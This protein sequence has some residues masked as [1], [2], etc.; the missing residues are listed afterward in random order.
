MKRIS[1]NVFLML[2]IVGGI[3]IAYA[4]TTFIA[5]SNPGATGGTNV[6]T[7]VNSINSAVTAAANGDIIYVVPSSVTYNGPSLNGKQVSIIGGGFNPNKPSGAVSTVSGIYANANNFRL[8]GIVF[9]TDVNIPGPFSNIMIDKCKLKVITDGSGGSAKG[10]LIIQNC[11]MGEGVG[12]AALYI[13]V[14][15][16]NV[17]IS[18]NIIYGNST[19]SYVVSNLN[20]AI[21]E[22][23]IFIG[24]ASGSTVPAF[25]LVTNCTVKNN[26]FYGIR[27]QGT[28]TANY[29]GNTLSNNL[30]FGASDNTFSTINGNTSVSNVV[31]K[32]PLFVNLPFGNSFSFSYDASLQATSPAKGTGLGGIDMGIFGGLNPYDIYGTSLPIVQA[33]TAPGVATQGSN[34]TVRV[35]A[36]GN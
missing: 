31:N 15:S 26:I 11:I 5:N 6:F 4:Q 33:V 32:N 36:K 25:N 12:G 21:I 29:T 16:T 3:R 34:L 24:S 8:S 23:N 18:N 7:G 14:G 28:S 19:A 22:N 2:F 9:T 35:Q 30:S 20:G 13:G 27:P 1:H 10:N 17:R